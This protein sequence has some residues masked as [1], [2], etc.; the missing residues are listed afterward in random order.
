MLD[1]T[2]VML[3]GPFAVFL[4]FIVFARSF[5]R[6]ADKSCKPPLYMLTKKEKLLEEKRLAMKKYIGRY[7]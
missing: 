6:A 5:L 7:V 1:F 3:T 2:F 4:F